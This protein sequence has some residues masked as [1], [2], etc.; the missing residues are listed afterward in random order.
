MRNSTD[1][2]RSTPLDGRGVSVAYGARRVVHDVD[3]ALRPGGVTALIGPNGSGKTTLLRGLCR[4]SDAEGEISLD[5][6]DAAS[7]SP[8]AFARRLTV[9]AQQ[10]P[11]PT[12]LTVVDVVG[13]GR[14]PHRRRLSR[15]DPGGAEAVERAMAL[16]GLEE[17]AHQP[18]AELSGGQLQRVWL[19]AC[20]A[21]QTDVLLLDEPTTFLDLKHQMSL[22]DLIRDLA[23][24]HGLTIGVVLHDL[25]Q[26]ADI[27]DHVVLLSEGE[28]VAA[29]APTEVMTS[30]R[31]SR[32]YDVPVDVVEM[33]DGRL[34]VR[35]RRTGRRAAASAARAEI[36]GA[37]GEETLAV[38]A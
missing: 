33:P 22:L 27:A 29:G 4:L 14:H 13:F 30:D 6:V 15:V 21:Q 5:D 10:R 9:L 34:T 17:L 36:A 37:A 28:V 8:R 20:L 1:Q 38:P 23:D 24:D 25:E 7:Y 18:V 35:A 31:L 26:A 11:T 16:A 32:V 19:A 12:G 2:A 3:V